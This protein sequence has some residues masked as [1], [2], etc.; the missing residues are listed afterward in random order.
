MKKNKLRLNY[1]HLFLLIIAI[2]LVAIGLVGMFYKLSG[3]RKNNNS[4]KIPD[5]NYITPT[6]SPKP[7]KSNYVANITDTSEQ[8]S[9]IVKEYFVKGM[10]TED[11]KK[12]IEKTD[13]YLDINGKYEQIN[14]NFEKDYHYYELEEIFKN[15][16]KSSIVKIEIIGVTA[17]GRNMYSLEIGD[18]EDVTMFEAGIHGA[19]SANPLFITKFMVDLVNNYES[20]DEN[21]ISLLKNHKIVILPSANPDGYEITRFGVNYLNNKNLYIGNANDE[22]REHIKM[23]AN[24]VDLNR[25]FP[26]QTAGLYYNR[27]RLHNSVVLDK[28]Y[29]MNSYFPGE[30]LGSEPET[31][32]IMYWQNKWISKLKS[33]VALHSAGRIIYNGKPYLSDEYNNNSNRCA[34]IV[35]NITNY[36]VLSKYDEEAGEGNDGTS[37][38]YMA[39]SLS[40]FIFST[41][42][43]RLSSDYY[44]KYYD[45]LKYHNTCVI[46]I[47][48]MVKYTNNLDVIKDE[49]YNRRFA[50]AYKAIIQ[51]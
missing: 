23:N 45:S 21:T 37:S 34:Y 11:Y 46:V 29:K 44:A 33:Y 13:N 26:S 35:G 22:E 19:E 51:R 24:G 2:I 3:N 36:T 30:T 28:S 8:N 41:V 25:N 5:N 38:E 9:D 4:S 48:A 20:G 18:G 40:G 27:Y 16:A 17:D 1:A 31:R 6:K 12:T 49:Y 32:A 42:T 50:D 15:L 43:G 39:E 14:Y 7:I 47:E 10:T